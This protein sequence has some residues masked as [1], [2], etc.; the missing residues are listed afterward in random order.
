MATVVAHDPLEYMDLLRQVARRYF[1]PGR[2]LDDLEQNGW[3]GLVKAC[4]TYDPDKGIEFERWAAADI[5]W[6]IRDSLGLDH[7]ISVPHAQR[8]KL[9]NGI[10]DDLSEER[11]RTLAAAKVACSAGYVGDHCLET[12]TIADLIEDREHEEPQRDARL[13]ELLPLIELLPDRQ[14]QVILLR[15]GLPEGP[16]LSYPEI[17]E[18][19]GCSVNAAYHAFSKGQ[20]KLRSHARSTTTANG[21]E[22]PVIAKANRFQAADPSLGEPAEV[23]PRRCPR[24]QRR[25]KNLTVK[26]CYYTDCQANKRRD[27]VEARASKAAAKASSQATTKVVPPAAAAPKPAPPPAIHAE[28]SAMQ[29][30]AD[31]PRAAAL[32]VVAWA[33]SYHKV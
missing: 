9:K 19:L 23:D 11:R 3:F 7:P 33:S 29:M 22:L 4:E 5:G 8:Q 31:L 28:F 1:R 18:Q 25:Y 17:A 21:Q 12:G 6:A 2:D 27:P 15:L 14:R 13:A 24:C 26:R 20:L 16:C 10:P 32:R 30:L